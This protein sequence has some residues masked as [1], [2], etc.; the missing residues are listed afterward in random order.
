MKSLL[1]LPGV[2]GGTPQPQAG[3]LHYSLPVQGKELPEWNENRG[4]CCAAKLSARA[5]AFS[6]ALD[7]FTVS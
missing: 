2:W 7:L 5:T 1:S 6:I 4:H 3:P